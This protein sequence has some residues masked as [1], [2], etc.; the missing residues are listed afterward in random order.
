LT[1]I[2]ARPEIEVHWAG[3]GCH[4]EPVL[5]A[6]EVDSFIADGFVAIRGAVPGDVIDACQKVIWD[7]LGKHGVTDDPA[8]WTAPVVRI[9]CPEGG[10]FVDA[11]TRP[12]VW[13]AC[14]QLIGGPDRWWRRPGVGGTLPVRFPSEGDPG[15]AG[16]HIEAS[17]AEDGD[18]RVNYRSRARGLLALYLLTDVDEASAPTRLR[19]GSHL[20]A[21][22]ILAPAGDAGMACWRRRRRPRRPPGTCPPRRPP[23]RRATCSSATRSSCTRRPGRTAARDRGWS[24]SPPSR[25]TASSR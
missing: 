21:A 4:S 10:P 8:T 6:N 14:D 20:D 22:R 17:Y 25:C 11:G 2:T 18:M 19:P 16:W 12:A 24:P 9:S 23:G 15:D 1:A 13:E 7:E 5:T 3:T